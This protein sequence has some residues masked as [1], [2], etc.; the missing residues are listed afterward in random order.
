LKAVPI[1]DVAHVEHVVVRPDGI[2]AELLRPARE[3]DERLGVLDP[4]VVEQRDSDPHLAVSY[5]T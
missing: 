1:E 4:P 5:L 3:A 2:E